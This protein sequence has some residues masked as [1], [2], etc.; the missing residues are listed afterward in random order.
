[1]NRS[2]RFAVLSVVITIVHFQ[3]QN[4]SPASYG[5]KGGDD[6]GSVSGLGA[7]GGT[8]NG[9][10]GGTGSGEIAVSCGTASCE[11]T[12]LTHK[13]TVTT[14]LLA[15]GDQHNQTL[16]ANNVS[17]Q[18]LVETIVRYSSPKDKPKI[19]IVRAKDTHG[20][21]PEDTL[22][23]QSLLSRYDTTLID[24][25]NSGLRSTDV[26]GFDVVWF[27][28]PG[29]PM[30]LRATF[31]TLMA[32]SGAV[33]LQGDDMSWVADKSFSMEPLTGLK[34]NDNG[35][36]VKCAEK[37][38]P[39]DNNAGHQYRVSLDSTKIQGLDQAAV[40]FRY[41]NDID[42]STVVG[43]NAEVLALAIGGPAECTETRPTVV[44]RFK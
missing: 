37:S 25:P 14:V 32:F 23:I 6:A 34:H 8:G 44:R 4:C 29:W 18:F 35:T 28:N 9:G 12:P 38:Y 7:G 16:V 26:A 20:E 27:N 41:G 24:E 30:S 42:N 40:N 1:M 13:P 11:L 43:A 2:K 19:L 31:D 22:Y 33:V 3:F 5:F 10:G 36:S 21:D 17:N 39:H 15:L